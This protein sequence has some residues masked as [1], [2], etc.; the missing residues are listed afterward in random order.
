MVHTFEEQFLEGTL[1][2]LLLHPYL[3][4]VSNLWSHLWHL[5]KR[6]W[7]NINYNILTGA[8][9]LFF[10][11]F[12]RHTSKIPTWSMMPLAKKARFYN[13]RTGFCRPRT[14]RRGRSP[15]AQIHS[16]KSDKLAKWSSMCLY[17]TIRALINIQDEHCFLS[18]IF[19]SNWTPQ[20][21]SY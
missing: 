5:Q 12:I 6:D 16:Y 17:C 15:P 4:L 18:I 14:Q 8:I 2:P 20:P 11:S 3:N 1:G 19:Y 10:F 9:T 21:A 7:Y 13:L